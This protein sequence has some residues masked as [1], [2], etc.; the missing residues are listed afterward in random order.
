MDLVQAAVNEIVPATVKKAGPAIV[1]RN[2]AEEIETATVTE[3]EIETVPEAAT[4]TTN[5]TT[6]TEAEIETAGK[7]V[8]ATEIVIGIDAERRSSTYIMFFLVHFFYFILLKN[9]NNVLL[10][11]FTCTCVAI[12]NVVTPM[13]CSTSQLFLLLYIVIP[14]T[15]IC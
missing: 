12:H 9:N 4:G 8:Q 6:E 5:V 3:T 7:E 1:N 11:L 15:A 13:L 14:N 2:H 10:I